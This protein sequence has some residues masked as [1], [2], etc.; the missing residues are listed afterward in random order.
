MN[1][2]P[3]FIS[4]VIEGFY[5]RPWTPDQRTRL[6]GWMNGWGLNTYL[7]APKDD[8]KHRTLWRE[9]YSD[10]EC[11]AL[12]RLIDDG[13][14]QGVEVVYAI[15]PGLDIQYATELPALQA[16][17][18]QVQALGISTF[19]V[20]FDDLP[21]VMSSSDQ[22]QFGTFGRAQAHVA[23]GLWAWLRAR[24]E[25][26][27]LWFCPTIYCGRFANDR[28]RENRYLLEVGAN[29]APDIEILW[30]GPQIISE[31]IPIDSIREL[32]TVLRR[33][34]LIWDNLHA[35]DYDLRRLYLGPYSGRPPELR[36]EVRGILSNP[37][38]EF[39]ANFI[40][41]HTLG[42]YVGAGDDWSPALALKQ[43]CA[44]WLPAFAGRGAHPIT[45]E[46][47]ELL[48][49]LFYLPQESGPRVEQW[50]EDF[51][52][53]VSHSPEKWGGRLERFD[54]TCDAVAALF[55]KITELADRELCFTLY[56][57][58]WEAQW[59]L[60]PMR[61]YI[62]WLRT[63]P[64]AGARYCPRADHRPHIYRDGVVA[65][66]QRLLPMGDDGSFGTTAT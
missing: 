13:R 29:L 28:V 14:R 27:Q 61:G 42:S 58:M 20:L 63:N 33:R 5:G 38:C 15:A 48:V 31:S 4:G 23:N 35:N 34:P 26:H 11:A 19:A 46:D 65:R 56:R 32:R 53:L 50:I 25:A 45:P 9:L 59:E 30:T 6:V 18:A 47:V 12:R 64:P 44:D 2:P 49:G 3:V 54:Q 52:F 41:L 22:A 39:E 51:R 57:L 1:A 24:N 7:Y 37:N 40:P 17:L 16:K 60:T 43:A 55:V 66:L 10:E 8:I 62:N 36:A 21:E